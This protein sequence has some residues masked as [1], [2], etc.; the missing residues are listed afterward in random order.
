MVLRRRVLI[1]LS[2]FALSSSIGGAA[3]GQ[4][5]QKGDIGLSY[6][7]LHDSEI[8]ETATVGWLVA[9][10]GNLNRF[11]GIVG[12]VGGNYKTIDV[13]GSSLDLSAH[14]FMAGVRFRAESPKAIPFAQFLVGA[15]RGSAGFLGQSDSSTDFAFQPGGGIDIRVTDRLAV[16]AQGDFRII[17]GD[18]DTTNQFRVAFG[19]AIGF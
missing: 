18:G 13:L 19:V 2:A 1:A 14:S 11:V 3:F 9:V 8:E 6:S 7:I 4:E 15:V 17:K 16:R 5:H 12:E 10:N